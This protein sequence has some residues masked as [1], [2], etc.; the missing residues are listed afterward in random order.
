MHWD[1][2]WGAYRR[3]ELA[4]GVNWDSEVLWKVWT[5]VLILDTCALYLLCETMPQFPHGR[6]RR[7]IAFSI[8]FVE[9]HVILMQVRSW[10]LEAIQAVQEQI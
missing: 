4:V 8:V 9:G 1:R 7:V 5:L 6:E 2:L 3:M 10:K